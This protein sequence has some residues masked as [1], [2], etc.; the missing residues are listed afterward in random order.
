MPNEEPEGPVEKVIFNQSNL[1]YFLQF[2][3]LVKI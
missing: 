3:F 2:Q 1:D